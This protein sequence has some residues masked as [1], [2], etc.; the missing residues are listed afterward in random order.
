MD[1]ALL[2][3]FE[4]P[5]D[6][7]GA[8]AQVKARKRRYATTSQPRA[9]VFSMRLYP[10][11]RVAIRAAARRAKREEMS[12]WAR[13]VLLAAAAREEVP[14][15]DEEAADELRRIRRDLNSGVGAN[16]N[17]AMRLANE[18]G[19]AGGSPD[20]DALAKAVVEAM[21]ALDLLRADLNRLIAPRGRR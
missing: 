7:Q 16:L 12:S 9:L 8:P 2:D 1:D 19:K 15:L 11:E 18:L 3:P 17:Q 4:L 21:S 6:E 13:E 5:D 14:T 20:E 10:G